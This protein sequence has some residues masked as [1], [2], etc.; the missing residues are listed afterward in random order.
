MSCNSNNTTL[1]TQIQ[2]DYKSNPQMQ[3]IKYEITIK[4]TRNKTNTNM[5]LKLKLKKKVTHSFFLKRKV[6]HS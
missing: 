1:D 6:T 2:P 3:R 4:L 5:K